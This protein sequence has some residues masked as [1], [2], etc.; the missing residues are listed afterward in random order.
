M[1]TINQ[2][3]SDPVD[4][5]FVQSIVRYSIALFLSLFVPVLYLSLI[6]HFYFSELWLENLSYLANDVPGYVKI[7][8]EHAFGI[9]YFG[10]YLL[11][12]F[13]T[14]APNPWLDHEIVT[15]PP[16]AIEIFRFFGTLP[17]KTGLV[18][19]EALLVVSLIA[20][21]AVATRK[22][23]TALSITATM[24]FGFLAGPTII[25]LDRGNIVGLLPIL[26]FIFGLSVLRG[27]WKTAAVAVVAAT[28][29]KY[30]PFV[31]SLILLSERKFRMWS[32]TFATSLVLVFGILYFYPGGFLESVNGLVRGALPFV[33][34]DTSDFSCYNTSYVSGIWRTL[35]FLGLGGAADWLASNALLTAILV[36]VVISAI[37]VFGVCPL[38]SKVVLTMCLSTI[39]TPTVYSY[40]L[41][42]VIAALAISFVGAQI[43]TRDNEN[44]RELVFA[45]L[46][47]E[48]VTRRVLRIFVISD[49]G[50]VK[51]T[52]TALVIMLVPWPFAIESSVALG[53]RTS[54]IGLVAFLGVSVIVLANLLH[55]ISKRQEFSKQFHD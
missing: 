42:W 52:V 43:T 44:C 46:Q 4:L 8:E 32:A 45:G 16:I 18:A 39:V 26:Y 25:S 50:L 33:S 13:W 53:C 7:R 30:F 49:H 9:H 29:L 35:T 48:A 1:N 31:L 55:W 34:D 11:P 40:S 38:W 54:I 28:S 47:N 51:V 14:E 23:G 27:Y 3:E 22:I 15:Y 12:H 36:T 6:R 2:Q 21:I 37:V 24:L 20:P 19:Y 5:D 17:Y 10:D 41:N